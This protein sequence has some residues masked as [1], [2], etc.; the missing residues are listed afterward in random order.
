MF[1]ISRLHFGVFGSRAEIAN[2]KKQFAPGV[3]YV[4]DIVSGERTTRTGRRVHVRSAVVGIVHLEEVLTRRISALQ[5][6]G[7]LVFDEVAN[8]EIVVGIAGDKEG[9]QTK[10]AMMIANSHTPNDPK[11]VFYTS[12][13]IGDQKFRDA[14]RLV[15]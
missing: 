6:T 3:T 14:Q 10:V 11:G 5:K 13:T 1:V 9:E 15:F 2:L 12:K 4:I 8:D 7:R